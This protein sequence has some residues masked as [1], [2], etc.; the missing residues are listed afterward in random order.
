[1]RFHS[2]VTK[3]SYL[4]KREAEILLSPMDKQVTNISSVGAE[5]LVS[6]KPAGEH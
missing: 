3:R 6:T 1:M 4:T 2:P 5:N